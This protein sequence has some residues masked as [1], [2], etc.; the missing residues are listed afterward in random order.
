MREESSSA[1]TAITPTAM[2]R[3]GSSFIQMKTKG[4]DEGEGEGE[5]EE[6]LMPLRLLLYSLV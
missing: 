3:E 2:F 6:K 1:T 5:G 4:E